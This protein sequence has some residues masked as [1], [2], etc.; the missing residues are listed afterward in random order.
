M[1]DAAVER[2][3]VIGAA[4][5]S[6]E[7]H[8]PADSDIAPGNAPSGGLFGLADMLGPCAP[9]RRREQGCRRPERSHALT[10]EAADVLGQAIEVD[11]AA[12]TTNGSQS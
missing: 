2:H 10:E 4:E 7:V 5:G 6:L 3:R 1:A 8:R 12:M 11:R 9:H